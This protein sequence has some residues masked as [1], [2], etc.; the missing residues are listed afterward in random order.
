M[1]E[2]HPRQ[3]P[4]LHPAQGLLK[5]EMPQF[6][7]REEQGGRWEGGFLQTRAFTGER[8]KRLEFSPA[9]DLR[10]SCKLV[11]NC[12]FIPI[13]TLQQVQEEVRK[14]FKAL[15]HFRKLS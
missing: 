15:L 2:G 10:A 14:D 7:L 11:L 1:K 13:E 4:S 6:Q 3:P 5:G 8:K 9:T 12:T